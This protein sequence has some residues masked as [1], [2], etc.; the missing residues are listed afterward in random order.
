MLATGC[1]DKCLRVF[2]MAASA[3]QSIKVF[4]GDNLFLERSFYC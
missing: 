1:E 2:F 3:S 4:T